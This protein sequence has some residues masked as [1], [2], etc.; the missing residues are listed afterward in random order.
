MERRESKIHSEDDDWKEIDRARWNME[1]EI[2]WEDTYRKE[3]NDVEV[4]IMG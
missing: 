1:K 4:A 2:H 3:M